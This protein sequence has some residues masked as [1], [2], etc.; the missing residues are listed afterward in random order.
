MRI[1][2]ARIAKSRFMR[3]LT[4]QPMTRMQIE[5]HRQIQPAFPS[6]NVADIARPFRVAD[7]RF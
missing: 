6:P 4:A 5:D 7:L 2:S 1:L 3:L